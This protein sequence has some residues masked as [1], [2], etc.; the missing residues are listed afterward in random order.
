MVGERREGEKELRLQLS[1][2]DSLPGFLT[3]DPE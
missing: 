3:M 2:L 1:S